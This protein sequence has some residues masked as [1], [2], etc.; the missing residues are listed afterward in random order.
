MVSHSVVSDSM[1][2]HGL[3]PTRLFRP[4]D[5]PGKSTGVGCHCL[6]LKLN[7]TPS[8]INNEPKKKIVRK[9]RK[10]FKV[11]ENVKNK[12]NKQ[13]KTPQNLWDA[14]KPMLRGK[15]YSFK[16]LYLERRKISNQ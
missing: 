14:A 1:R 3:Q 2:P 6:L 5:F 10:Y 12:T 9:I 13:T 15:N 16:C 7:H 11:N 8:Q 4:W